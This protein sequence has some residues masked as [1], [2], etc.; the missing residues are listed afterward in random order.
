LIISKLSVGGKENCPAK[1]LV[2]EIAWV[3]RVMAT[4]LTST[5]AAAKTAETVLS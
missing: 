2:T 3:T 5:E 4:A 1:Q